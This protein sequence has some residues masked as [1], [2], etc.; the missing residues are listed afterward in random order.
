MK[1]IFEQFFRRARAFSTEHGVSTGAKVALSRVSLLALAATFELTG[2]YTQEMKEEIADWEDGR[3]VG[4]GVLPQ[5]PYITVEK[6]ADGFR[7]LGAG[8]RDPHISILFKNLDSA[9]LIFTGMLGAPMA[10][11]E[12]RVC[13]QGNN[14][15]AMQVTRAMAIVQTYLFPGIILKNTFKRPPRLSA[16]QLAIKAK[17]M[18]LLTPKLLAAL[19]K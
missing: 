11:A 4:I 3:R 14:Y 7:I 12:N 18:G 8:L 19:N 1:E 15:H 9:I 13:V 6:H 16:G 2:K 17:I 10:V 5:G